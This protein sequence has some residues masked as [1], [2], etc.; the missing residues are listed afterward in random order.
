[1][2]FLNIAVVITYS[3]HFSDSKIQKR[4]GL[5]IVGILKIGHTR[6]ILFY[7]VFPKETIRYIKDDWKKNSIINV[8]N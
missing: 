1:M 6:K 3:S 4:T 7:L 5:E 8:K 2:I